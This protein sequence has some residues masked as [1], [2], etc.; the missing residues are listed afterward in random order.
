[1][2]ENMKNLS[3]PDLNKEYKGKI[4]T[5]LYEPAKMSDIDQDFAF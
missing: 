4:S 3:I 2:N 5:S 1:M